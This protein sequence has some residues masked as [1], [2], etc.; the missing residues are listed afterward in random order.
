MTLRFLLRQT[1]GYTN[2]ERSRKQAD[3]KADSLNVLS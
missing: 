1:K 3:G 2:L